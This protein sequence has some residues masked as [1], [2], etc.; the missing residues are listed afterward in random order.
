MALSIHNAACGRCHLAVRAGTIVPAA[1]REPIDAGNALADQ[2]QAFIFRHVHGSEDLSVINFSVQLSEA[3][4]R[5][6]N[7]LSNLFVRL[8]GSTIEQSLIRCRIARAKDLLREGAF[9]L[10][11][12]AGLLHYSSLAH[13]SAQF[14]KVTGM[15]ATRYRLLQKVA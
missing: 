7:Y 10:T 13:L 9:S 14:R 6:Y 2:I 12:I 11:H 8:R 1:I 15:T 3:M 5:N 4:D